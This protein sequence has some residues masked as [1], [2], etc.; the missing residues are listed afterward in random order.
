METRHFERHCAEPWLS[1]IASGRKQIEG[2]LRRSIFATLQPGDSVTWFDGDK[3]VRTR[4]EG[5]RGYPTFRAMLEAEGL[6]NVLPEPGIDTIEDGVAV[7]RQYFTEE[8]ERE[9]GVLAVLVSLI[10]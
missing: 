6:G 7:Y 2:R 10:D 3:R 8:E 5:A 4:I 9:F 1:H